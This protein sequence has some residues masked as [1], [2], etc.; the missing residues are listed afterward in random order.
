M[1]P[2]RWIMSPSSSRRCARISVFTAVTDLCCSQAHHF[3]SCSFSDLLS[4]SVCSHCL[5]SAF[6]CT[7]LLLRRVMP[8][9][10]RTSQAPSTSRCDHLLGVAAQQIIVRFRLV[11]N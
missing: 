6:G 5:C 1:R 7:D 3:A 4:F 9:R 2:L 10:P 8:N 11:I